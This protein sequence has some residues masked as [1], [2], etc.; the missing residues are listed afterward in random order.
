VLR[1]LFIFRLFF[2]MTTFLETDLEIQEAM[3]IS[4]GVVDDLDEEEIILDLDLNSSDWFYIPEQD[5]TE[6]QDPVE[7]EQDPVQG[8]S[9]NEKRE[10]LNAFFTQR[11]KDGG[12]TFQNIMP[13]FGRDKPFDE[14]VVQLGLQENRQYAS[15]Q[16]L[17]FKKDKGVFRPPSFAADP[18]KL[19]MIYRHRIERYTVENIVAE[20]LAEIA[21]F[22]FQPETVPAKVR[23]H[24]LLFA[25]SLPVETKL[26]EVLWEM[27][28]LLA[29]TI[30]GATNRTIEEKSMRVEIHLVRDSVLALNAFARE[31]VDMTGFT[32]MSTEEAV[33]PTNL[34]FSRLHRCLVKGW[35]RALRESTA[36]TFVLDLEPYDVHECIAEG[37]IGTLYYVSGW[38]LSR[39]NKTRKGQVLPDSELRRKFVSANS[40][41]V[42]Q[43]NSAPFAVID[44]SRPQISHQQLTRSGKAWFSFVS[45]LEA[46]FIVNLTEENAM[47]YRANLFLEVGKAIRKSVSLHDLFADCFP[48]TFSKDDRKKMWRMYFVELLPPYAMMKGGDVLRGIRAMRKPN[49]T[50]RLSTRSM[51]VAANTAAASKR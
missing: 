20:A 48:T 21:T 18:K 30:A 38:L 23:D 40:L 50:N 10:R 25:S 47:R 14:L 36:T 4:E 19:M 45:L 41:S 17:K 46:L 39:L 11:L 7:E 12:W 42:V 34:F 24:F 32:V 31:K 5:V 9:F 22:T 28:E 29:S 44:D 27:T 6:A 16:W 43:A 33:V 3:D 37:S 2:T 51:V 35:R 13:R 15:S 1:L 26:V 49:D 8:L